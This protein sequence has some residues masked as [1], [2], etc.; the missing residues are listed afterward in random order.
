MARGCGVRA[1]EVGLAAVRSTR[2]GDR[3]FLLGFCLKLDIMYI[4]DTGIE[5]YV[6][7]IYDYQ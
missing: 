5:F 2:M 1:G 4:E 3:G 6:G 7:K